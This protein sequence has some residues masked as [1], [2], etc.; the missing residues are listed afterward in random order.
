MQGPYITKRQVFKILN[1]D[2][3]ASPLVQ[4]FQ[5]QSRSREPPVPWKQDYSITGSVITRKEDNE[6]PLCIREYVQD[7][8]S[9]ASTT[10]MGQKIQITRG[11]LQGGLLSPFLFNIT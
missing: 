3:M 6:M 4:C 11:V 1:A 8:Y 5:F 10:I 9:K 2:P 7:L